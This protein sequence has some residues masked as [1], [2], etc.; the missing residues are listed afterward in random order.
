M[1]KLNSMLASL[2]NELDTLKR[3]HANAISEWREKVSQQQDVIDG[4]KSQ[5]NSSRLAKEEAL[6]HAKETYRKS[7]ISLRSTIHELEKRAEEKRV[8]SEGCIGSIARIKV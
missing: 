5:S 8:F 7:A 2:R 6:R 4:F 1:I 3:E